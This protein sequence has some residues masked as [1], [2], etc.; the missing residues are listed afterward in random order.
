[1]SELHI[2]LLVLGIFNYLFVIILSCLTAYFF[3]DESPTSKLPWA[4]CDT[5]IELI[6]MLKLLAGALIVAADY[7]FTYSALYLIGFL[8]ADIFVLYANTFYCSYL[9][10]IIQAADII[11]ACA[12]GLYTINL[13]IL[14]VFFY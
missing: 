3:S 1:M 4:L 12:T 7:K 13:A 8:S 11:C 6:K 2:V 14:I 10:G 5:R 9:Y